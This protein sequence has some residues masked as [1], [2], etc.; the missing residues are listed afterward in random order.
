MLVLSQLLDHPNMNSLLD[1]QQSVYRTQTIEKILNDLLTV[2]DSRDN[3]VL[4]L[5][6][7]SALFDTI[8]HCILFSRLQSSYG[9]FDT[10]L[11]LFRSYLNDPSQTV[12]AN[13]LYSTST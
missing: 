3:S 13:G 10:A 4:S 8:N 5:L 7:L 11:S 1:P 9:I 6:D 2:L 12:S